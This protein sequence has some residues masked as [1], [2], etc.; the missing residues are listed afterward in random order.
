ML[1]AVEGLVVEAP[2]EDECPGQSMPNAL[3]AG[4]PAPGPPDGLLVLEGSVSRY[5]ARIS[6]VPPPPLV[7]VE[8]RVRDWGENAVLPAGLVKLRAREEDISLWECMKDEGW[9]GW[10][11]APEKKVP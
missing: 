6:P 7:V 9:T 11:G 2:L 4:P 5:A 1:V 8:G 3:V 10:V